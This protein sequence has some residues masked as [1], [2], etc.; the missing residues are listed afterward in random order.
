[1]A[2]DGTYLSTSS[3]VSYKKNNVNNDV[4][5][6]WFA[7][8]AIWR[9]AGFTVCSAA[10]P[11]LD[12]VPKKLTDSC[13][14]F[15]KLFVYVPLLARN[16]YIPFYFYSSNNSPKSLMIRHTDAEPETSRGNNEAW[17]DDASIYQLIKQMRRTKLVSYMLSFFLNSVSPVQC[18][19][20]WHFHPLPDDFVRLRQWCER[21]HCG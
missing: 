13:V 14:F 6:D 7:F 17:I 1:M 19:I 4:C 5:G 21:W 10:G 16:Q 15:M 3:P 8:W 20:W 9:T 11:I 12:C 18:G 2:M